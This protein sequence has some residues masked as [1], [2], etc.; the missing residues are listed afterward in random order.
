[1]L[2]GGLSARGAIRWRI[3]PFASAKVAKPKV[4]KVK[5]DAKVTAALD[6]RPSET[7]P[8]APRPK[9][10]PKAHT[11][12]QPLTPIVTPIPQPPEPPPCPEDGSDS[13]SKQYDEEC[14]PEPAGPTG[15]TGVTGVTGTAGSTENGGTEYV[16][17]TPPTTAP[18]LAK[19]PETVNSE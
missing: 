14:P 19:T 15:A 17:G 11:S 7:I 2:G 6:R 1:L 18:E 9:K 16:E 13:A 8:N 5:L 3:G 10:Q 4:G 12:V